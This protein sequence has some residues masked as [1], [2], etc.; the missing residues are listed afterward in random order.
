M[1]YTGELIFVA[2]GKK[3]PHNHQLNTQVLCSEKVL[4]L[5]SYL[6]PWMT[7]KYLHFTWEIP[8]LNLSVERNFRLNLSQSLGQKN[9]WRR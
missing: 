5:C 9:G 3:L 6:N 7:Y 8:T 1:E 4:V 2:D